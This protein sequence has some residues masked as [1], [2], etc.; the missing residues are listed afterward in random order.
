MHLVCAKNSKQKFSVAKT[1]LSTARNLSPSLEAVFP[2]SIGA[3]YAVAKAVGDRE[4]STPRQCFQWG[5]KSQ[6]FRRQNDVEL[7][8]IVQLVS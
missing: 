3:A 2:R 7:S 1:E 8:V 5:R 4:V 6:G